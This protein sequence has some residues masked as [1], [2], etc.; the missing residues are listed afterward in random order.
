VLSVAPGVVATAM[1]ARIRA[2]DE[3]DFPAV[4]RFVQLYDEQQLR[5]P[6][7]AAR[8]VWSVLTGITESGAVLDVRTAL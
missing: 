8:D 3:A 7:D 4:G 6:A 5:D 1:Q 2:T